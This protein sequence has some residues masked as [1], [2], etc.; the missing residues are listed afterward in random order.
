MTTATT[1]NWTHPTPKRFAQATSA[2]LVV[3]YGQPNTLEQRG[4]TWVI[5]MPHGPEIHITKGPLQ[6]SYDA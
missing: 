6:D 2:I 3:D 1:Y 4:R 5:V